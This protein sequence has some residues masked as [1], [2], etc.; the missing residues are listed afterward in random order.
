MPNTSKYFATPWGTNQ[1]TNLSSIRNGFFASVFSILNSAGF[2]GG[3][4]PNSLAVI[5]YKSTTLLSLLLT[6]AAS[7][8]LITCSPSAAVTGMGSSDRI[9]LKTSS[10]YFM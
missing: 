9:D 6:K 8:T 1:K 4:V 7:I 2:E 3:R 5:C 10:K